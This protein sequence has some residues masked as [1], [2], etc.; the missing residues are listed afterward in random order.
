MQKYIWHSEI[1]RFG[2]LT[3]TGNNY[4]ANRRRIVEFICDCGTV[5]WVRFDGIKRGLCTSCGCIVKERLKLQKPASTHGLSEHP[6]YRVFKDMVKRCYQKKSARY[7]RYGARG[8]KVCD[9]WLKDFKKFYDWSIDNGWAPDRG[10][11]VDRKDNDGNYEPDNC[12]WV[13]DPVQRRNKSSNH[14]VEIFGETKCLQAWAEDSRC[15]VKATVLVKRLKR[16]WE[17]ERAISVP[18]RK[19]K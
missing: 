4:F 7:Y 16:G 18:L 14:N 15:V 6:L 1:K 12:R 13:L 5:K 8:I 19:N 9:L 10:L 2:N 11:S 17:A 3:L